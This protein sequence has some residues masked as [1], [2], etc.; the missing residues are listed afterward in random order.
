MN[1]KPTIWNKAYAIFIGM[2]FTVIVTVVLASMPLISLM[3]R[4]MNEKAN[5]SDG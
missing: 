2:G 4:T 5:G 1:N 3:S